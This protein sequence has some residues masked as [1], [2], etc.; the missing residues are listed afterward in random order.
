MERA[1]AM[2]ATHVDA[3]VVAAFAAFAGGE[4]RLGKALAILAGLGGS[5][6]A[7]DDGAVRSLLTADPALRTLRVSHPPSGRVTPSQVTK[8]CKALGGGK[9]SRV[10][11]QAD[12]SGVFDL[13]APRAQRLVDAARREASDQPD[14]LLSGGFVVELPSSL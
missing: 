13:P 5:Q 4:A 14:G 3:D 2:L 12:G 9:I 11:V 1:T 8:L 6:R 7:S 10:V